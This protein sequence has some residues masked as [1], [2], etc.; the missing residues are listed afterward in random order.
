M[1]IKETCILII[2]NK[3]KQ[4]KIYANYNVGYQFYHLLEKLNMVV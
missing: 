4:K 2:R 3:I 1:K